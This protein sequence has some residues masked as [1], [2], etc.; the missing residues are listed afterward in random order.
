M[1]RY[2]R[3]VAWLG[4]IPFRV[5]ID[6]ELL[7][8]LILGQSLAGGADDD[9]RNFLQ[10]YEQLLGTA[11]DLGLSNAATQDNGLFANDHGVKAALKGDMARL[12]EELRRNAPLP[13]INDQVRLVPGDADAPAELTIRILPARQLPDAVMFQATTDRRRFPRAYPSG[14][15]VAA[16]CGSPFAIAN[17]EKGAEY[18]DD[19]LNAIGDLPFDP[20]KALH[21]THEL[22]LH[23]ENAGLYC[24]YLHALSGLFEKPEKDVPALFSSKAWQIKSCQTALG[25]W[26]QMRHA[27][28]LQAKENEFYF[29]GT[30]QPSGFIEPAPEFF[31]RFAQVAERTHMLMRNGGAF[32]PNP[33][34]AASE[35]RTVAHIIE[36]LGVNGKKVDLE[37]L[38]EDQVRQIDSVLAVLWILREKGEFGTTDVFPSDVPK[39]RALA[40]QLDRGQLPANAEIRKALVRRRGPDVEPMWQSLTSLSR[41]LEAL[42]H[43]Q[44]RDIAFNE[45]EDAFIISYGEALGGCMLYFR[46]SYEVPRDDAPRVADV[47]ANP[48]DGKLLE[49][50]IARA[51]VLY[52]LYPWHGQEIL[53]RGAVMPYYE[54]K[55]ARRLTDEQWKALLDS[56]QRP[57]LPDWVKPIY[58]PVE[59]G[60]SVSK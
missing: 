46:N 43:K 31:S 1:E 7:S 36:K 47:F 6:E 22:K 26:A 54:F 10:P 3:A 19:L 17:L 8:A 58:S 12:R 24:L 57:Q 4:A 18:R 38:P 32:D 15:E 33:G 27:W 2:F 28:I 60:K 41:R 13:K 55:S 50:G 42:A 14:L 59:S 51:R 49:V 21:V 30:S 39:L 45:E 34:A 40:D 37:K 20:R 56:P 53:C 16:M 35:L 23:T 5:D 52:V 44:L 25:G 11:D 9:L 29:G 48:A